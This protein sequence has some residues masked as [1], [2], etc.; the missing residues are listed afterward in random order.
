MGRKQNGGPTSKMC[1]LMSAS[2]AG[3]RCRFEDSGAGL[4]TGLELI[5]TKTE[6]EQGAQTHTH[7]FLNGAVRKIHM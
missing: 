4:R 3:L 5:P 6:T 1:K 2:G 7:V